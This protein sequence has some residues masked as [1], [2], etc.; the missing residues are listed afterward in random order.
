[1]P[2]SNKRKFDEI[3]EKSEFINN[4]IITY[5]KCLNIHCNKQPSFNYPSE[6]KYLY[7][8]QH[9]LEGMVN[10][11]GERCIHEGCSKLASF[12]Y[13]YEKICL[14]CS[15]H[16]L[17]G[18]VNI[19]PKKCIHEGC[20]KWPSF[21]FHENIKPLYCSQHKLEGMVN[22][23]CKRCIHEGCSKLASFNYISE[24]KRLYC[25]EHKLKEMVNLITYK[26]SRNKTS[27]SKYLDELQDIEIK[28]LIH[29]Y[30]HN[31]IQG[32]DKTKCI[33]KECNKFLPFNRNAMDKNLYCV[34]HEMNN[35]SL[36]SVLLS[37]V[38]GVFGDDELQKIIDL[39]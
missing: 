29:Q 14:Y 7:C 31:K 28:K 15:S 21:N 39:L 6:T 25:S 26:H 20:T 12:N 16:K 24:K 10:T 4:N 37:D 1:M 11:R 13:Q 33:Y 32:I 9:K 17:E 3:S 8:S 23:R 35:I 27:L 30:D 34:Q 22:I 5:N 36:E 2:K 18:M 19:V 38:D